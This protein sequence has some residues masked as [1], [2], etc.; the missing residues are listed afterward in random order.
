MGFYRWRLQIS[1]AAALQPSPVVAHE[2]EYRSVSLPTRRR[3]FWRRLVAS[4]GFLRST[5]AILVALTIGVLISLPPAGLAETSD[6][7]AQFATLGIGAA[8]CSRVVRA[9]RQTA[10]VGETDRQTMIA[11]AQGYLSFYNAVSEGTYDVTGG[12]DAAVLQVRLFD[13]CRQNPQA[14]VMNAVDQ[15]LLDGI[16]HRLLKPIT[17]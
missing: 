14:S 2:Q 8:P 9:I 3:R 11:W 4:V 15:L 12:V 17:H 7:P 10:Q 6:E 16:T 5:N 1:M 13:F